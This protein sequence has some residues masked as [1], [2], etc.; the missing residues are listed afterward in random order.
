MKCPNCG[1]DN[2]NDAV[3]CKKCGTRMETQN[4]KEDISWVDNVDFTEGIEWGDDT[5]QQEEK[6][7]P[8]IELD[9]NQKQRAQMW[10]NIQ[11]QRRQEAQRKAAGLDTEPD[12]DVMPGR[13]RGYDE[14]EIP[15]DMPSDD[16]YGYD[17]DEDYD[18]DEYDYRDD[19]GDGNRPPIGLFVGIIG[20][21]AAIV[22]LAIVLFNVFSGGGTGYIPSTR[23]VGTG[24][25]ASDS[26]AQ[27]TAAVTTTEAVTEESATQES[28]TEEPTTEEPTTEEPTTEEPTTEE[29]TT[30]E[31]TTEP[32]PDP[33]V[34][35]GITYR[36]DGDSAR[37]SDYAGSA[38][39]VYIASEINGYP[40][41]YVDAEAFSACYDL[42][43]L[44]IPEGVVEI[45][46]N[47]FYDCTSLNQIVIPS[48]VTEIGQGAFDYC[49]AFTIVGQEGTYAQQFAGLYN[50]N[51]VVGSDFTE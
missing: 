51:F 25:A 32:V 33:V 30:E 48:T 31:P 15:D 11:R 2:D 24:S 46:E 14:E 34:Q 29:P 44:Y 6:E 9:L 5:V 43:N 1:T 22:V 27:T 13:N 18:F 7:K 40:V 12:L 38:S 23:P 39:E 49:P 3:F 28:T 50:V 41:R 10:E 35:D 19:D 36:F 37:V 45:G 21:V 8:R 20:V 26:S 4:D 47:A 16:L 17:D 42:Q